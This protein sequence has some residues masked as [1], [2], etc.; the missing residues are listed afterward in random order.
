MTGSDLEPETGLGFSNGTTED[1]DGS[2]LELRFVFLGGRQARQSFI[3]AI[4]NGSCS[5]LVLTSWSARTP[6]VK[7]WR[8]L[9]EP[10]CNPTVISR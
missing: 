10:F 7:P 8:S 2:N 1:A 4:A 6:L 9:A 3:F 5:W